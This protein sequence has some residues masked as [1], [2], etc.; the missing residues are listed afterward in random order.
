MPAVAKVR[1]SSR[2]YSSQACLEQPRG[3]KLFI[4]TVTESGLFAAE[5]EETCRD[6]C[7]SVHLD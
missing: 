2:K 4:A 1:N 7:N 6:R 3:L 5:G